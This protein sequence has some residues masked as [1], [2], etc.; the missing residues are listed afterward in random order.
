MTEQAEDTIAAQ[1]R[2]DLLTT[3]KGIAAQ[4]ESGFDGYTKE[5][6]L[7]ELATKVRAA[8][9]RLESALDRVSQEK[10]DLRAAITKAEE[11]TS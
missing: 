11:S 9:A 2:R 8:I 3:L 6:A 10:T 4:A 7:Y 5:A 1:E